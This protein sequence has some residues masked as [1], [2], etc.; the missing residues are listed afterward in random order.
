MDIFPNPGIVAL[1]DGEKGRKNFDRG[2]NRQF[3]HSPRDYFLAA[4]Y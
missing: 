2:V 1:V 4:D 3:V